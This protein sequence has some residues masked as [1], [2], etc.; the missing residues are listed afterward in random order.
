MADP[1]ADDVKPSELDMRLYAGIEVLKAQQ[2][3]ANRRLNKMETLLET[4]LVD[5]ARVARLEEWQAEQSAPTPWKDHLLQ[6]F[7]WGIG[8]TVLVGVGKIFG[9]EVQW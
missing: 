9:V 7:M 5:P 1:A 2:S 8:I 6:A 4:N 3:E